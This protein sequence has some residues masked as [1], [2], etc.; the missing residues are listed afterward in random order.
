MPNRVPYTVQHDH[1]KHGMTILRQPREHADSPD[2]FQ[3]PPRKTMKSTDTAPANKIT[4]RFSSMED[5]TKLKIKNVPSRE[6]RH[7]GIS[8]KLGKCRKIMFKAIQ[9]FAQLH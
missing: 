1:I 6:H 4:L 5:H 9:E 8:S 3:L 2:Q 7:S